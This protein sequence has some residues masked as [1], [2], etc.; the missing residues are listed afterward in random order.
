MRRS[1]AVQVIWRRDETGLDGSAGM[2]HGRSGKNDVGGVMAFGAHED[3]GRVEIVCEHEAIDGRGSSGRWKPRGCLE[4][5]GRS[6][7]ALSIHGK[8]S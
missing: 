1:V 3:E 7:G 5:A 8:F 2:L 4:K 6:R